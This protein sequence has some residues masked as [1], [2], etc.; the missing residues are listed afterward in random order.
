MLRYSAVNFYSLYFLRIILSEILSRNSTEKVM[1]VEDVVSGVRHI[2]LE[3]NLSLFL[4][5]SETE[6][7]V[8]Q[9]RTLTSIFVK[10]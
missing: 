7:L 4:F 2:D 10:W 8:Q 9:S 6:E 1:K 3:S 5:V